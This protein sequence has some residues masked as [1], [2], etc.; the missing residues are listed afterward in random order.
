MFEWYVEIICVLLF[1]HLHVIYI[2]SKFD[3]ITEEFKS[4]HRHHIW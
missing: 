3:M 2:Q 4:D 1:A